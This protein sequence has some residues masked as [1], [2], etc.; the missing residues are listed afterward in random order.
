MMFR[1]AVLFIT[2]NLACA[3]IAPELNVAVSSGSNNDFSGALAPSVKWST[4]GNVGG[5]DYEGG[6]N[7]AASG[8][9]QS[10]LPFSVWGKLRR[11]IGDWGVTAKIDANSDDLGHVDLDLQ[12]QG[13]PT[14]LTLMA[15]G[16]VDAGRQS[17][18]LR[19]VGLQQSFE[20]PGGNLSLRPRFNLAQ[21]KAD[22]RVEYEHDDTRLQVDADMDSQRI[23]L[24]Q[25]L[26]DNNSISPSISSN[27]DI[28]LEYRRNIGDGT[29]TANYKPNDST[30]LK[31]EEGPWVASAD[32]PMDGYYNFNGGAKLNVRRSVNLE[33]M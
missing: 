21:G 27:G 33:V 16:S 28:E 9:A 6:V 5:T 17:G 15:Q 3:G 2:L 13:G 23:T 11:E 29:L 19:E 26:D 10:D 4:E 25:R 12:A 7:L 18:E 14:D 32:I 30:S 31:Y 1:A 24:A 8:L 20:A 22:V